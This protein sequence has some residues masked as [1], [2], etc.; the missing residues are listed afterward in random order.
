VGGFVVGK[1][2][3]QDILLLF[4]IKKKNVLQSK[5]IL[6]E[7]PEKVRRPRAKRK[8]SEEGGEER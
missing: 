8:P 1:V 6:I 4:K 2:I 3:M 5:K 7:K